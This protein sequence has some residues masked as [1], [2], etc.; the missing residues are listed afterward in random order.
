MTC[1][2]CTFLVIASLA[3]ACSIGA[4]WL[5]FLVVI[6]ENNI[7]NDGTTAS[8][9]ALAPLISSHA[10]KAAATSSSSKVR[11][12]KEQQL[13]GLPDNSA[14]CPFFNGPCWVGSHPLSTD[15]VAILQTL[16]VVAL[17][18]CSALGTPEDPGHSRFWAC[19]AAAL[20]GATLLIAIGHASKGNNFGHNA[21][22]IKFGAAGVAG[23]HVGASIAAIAQEG[24]IAKCVQNAFVDLVDFI[25]GSYTIIM[26]SLLMTIC[27][28]GLQF[29]NAIGMLLSW[30]V[31][32]CGAPA[33]RDYM[34]VI[35]NA[36]TTYE[37]PLYPGQMGTLPPLPPPQQSYDPYGRQVTVQYAAP[38]YPVGY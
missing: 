9:S 15:D 8:S 19:V 25:P 1:C 3:M 2:G 29:L 5:P 35:V 4:L 32:C 21:A 22:M 28:S 7:N 14:Q 38:G 26:L 6:P 30:C 24:P 31:S 36:Q 20:S 34:L 37:Q 23:M 13:S 27:A 17:A 10:R 12:M 16:H 33:G 11:S 18:G